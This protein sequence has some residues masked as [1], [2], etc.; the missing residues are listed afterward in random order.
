MVS[1]DFTVQHDF[2]APPAQVWAAMI[3][4]EAH[5]DWIPATRVEID[6]GDPQAVGGE[7]TGYTGYGPL[8]LVDRMRVN[9]IDWHDDTSSGYCEVEKLGPVMSGTAGF[10]LTPTPTGNGARI[11]WF[12]KVTV[13]KIPGFLGPIISKVGALG[14][15]FAMK[16]FAA[17]L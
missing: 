5:G 14:F 15:S 17:T 2:D 9:Q 3:N 16:R 13:A 1:I 10:T 6:A 8:T 12:E 11:E 7:F 4:W